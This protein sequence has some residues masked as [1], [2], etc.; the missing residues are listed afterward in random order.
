MGSILNENDRVEI[1]NRLRS[2]SVS[3]KGSWGS[4]DVIGMLQ[5]LRTYGPR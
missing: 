4:M 1:C 3:S 5:P 2:L